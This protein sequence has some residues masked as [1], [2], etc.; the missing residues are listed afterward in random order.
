MTR[1]AGWLLLAAGLATPGLAAAAKFECPE[2]SG[3]FADPEQ[4]DKYWVCHAGSAL[5]LET[6]VY[7][8]GCKHGEGPG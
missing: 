5:E 4:C 7:A 1:P 3:I 8:K 6:E 2:L